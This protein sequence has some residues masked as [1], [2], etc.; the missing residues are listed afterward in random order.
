[1]KKLIADLLVETLG[2][3][4]IRNIYAITG[5]SANHITDSISRSVIRF[6]HTRHEESAAFAAAAEA[7]ATGRLAVCM[8]S[9]GPGS[10]HLVN[11]L[12]EAQRNG[13]PV[14]AIATE[15]HR[16]QI[17]TRFIQEIDTR[18]VFR[19]CSHF[20][21]YIR[22]ADQLPRLMGIA[23]QTAI[24]RRGVAVIIITAEVSST[25]ISDDT[26][27]YT[28]F[29]PT[30]IVRPSNDELGQIA[31]QINSAS[32][33]TIFSGA[34]SAGATDKVKALSEKIKAPL[35]WTVRAKEGHDF[36]TPYPAG[37][38]GY[39]GTSAG[40]YA[41]H[42]CDLLLL[43]GCGFAF[44]NMYPDNIPIIQID[45]SGENLARRH[46][47]TSGY[48]GDIG[49]TLELLLPL[50]DER[51]DSSFAQECADRYAQAR[52]HLSSLTIQSA[53]SSHKIYPEHLTS[54]L[55]NKIDPQAWITADVG[56]PWAFMARYIDSKGGR[57]IFSSSL[58]GT[59]AAALPFTIGLSLADPTKQIV[60]LC[61]D[62]GLTMLFGE[63]LT[64][65]QEK[66]K[67]KIIVY[68]NS[69]LDFVSME[70]KADGMLDS[71][72]DLTE[73]NFA[74][75]ATAIGIKGIRV[76]R[77]GDLEAAIDMAMK[78]DGAVLV[79]VV[80]DPDSMIIPPRIT[81]Q[82]VGQYAHYVSKMVRNSRAEEALKEAI[83]NL[84]LSK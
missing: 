57:R 12:Y 47:I 43:L 18:E 69:R 63:L 70:M 41:T 26:V 71:F 77:S 3:T 16:S 55:N 52:E 34:G 45:I 24:S 10:L 7:A 65:V 21:E 73:T 4:G 30:P 54:T 59:M 56:T 80:V 2:K 62:G 28:P 23:M 9:C 42:N 29:Y 39:L 75:I 51:S 35:A 53:D 79:D 76:E 64:V 78:Y 44:D 61:G 50:V 66:L 14:L 1:M 74:A 17:G 67:P 84:R 83:I 31:S 20:C 6:V 68:N 40:D 25:E 38:T 13:V 33:V 81:A 27:R 72:T 15:I 49:A 8:G 60:A 82:M 48:V 37:I 19:G 32:K 36:E 5:D 58:H 22:S 46:N 11:G